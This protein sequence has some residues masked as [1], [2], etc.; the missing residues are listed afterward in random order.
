MIFLFDFDGVL[1]KSDYFSVQ[2][3]KDFGVSPQTISTFFRTEFEKCAAGKA[4]LKD[5]LMN[6]ITEWKWDKGVDELLVYWFKHDIK[7]D[8]ELLNVAKRLRKEGYYCAIASQQEK[9]RKHHIWHEVGLKNI[10]NDFY[11][12][13]DLGY[14]KRNPQYYKQVLAQLI[15]HGHIEHHDEVVYWDDSPRFIQA[16]QLE[17]IP[18]IH[19][20]TNQDITS[21][22]EH[23]VGL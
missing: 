2:F 13:C 15:D 17:G 20:Q 3:E 6:Y 9:Y 11:C 8:E 4:D 19:F 1:N 14:L 10:F 23:H 21:F 22:V 18:A 7:I 5:L 12:T 16:A